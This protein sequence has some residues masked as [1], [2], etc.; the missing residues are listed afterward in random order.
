[1]RCKRSGTK[2]S[3]LPLDQLGTLSPPLPKHLFPSA[4][5]EALLFQLSALGKGYSTI[6]QDTFLLNI[7]TT[8]NL[9]FQCKMSIEFIM[10]HRK[11]L[12]WM[13]RGI[14]PPDLLDC[15]PCPLISQISGKTSNQFGIILFYCLFY[16]KSL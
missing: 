14:L 11:P 8:L 5:C 1:M 7:S 10:A 9:L 3:P 4:N 16:L 6:S 12:M 13:S 2:R 15:P